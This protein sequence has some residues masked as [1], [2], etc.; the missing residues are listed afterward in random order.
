MVSKIGIS[1][2]ESKMTEVA[3]AVKQETTALSPD[4]ILQIGLSFWASKALL[5]AIGLQV[6]TKLS[7]K[8]M[9]GKDLA[10]LVGIHPRGA[11]DFFDT[12]LSLGMLE[13][14]NGVYE[15]SAQSEH[16]LVKGKG[17]YIGGI[18]E[19]SDSRM[20][21]L[22]AK[23]TEALKTGEPQMG[24]DAEE[25]K[26]FDKVYENPLALE[27]F[28]SAMTGLTMGTAHA[29]AEKF[30]WSK[31]KNFADV[32][33]AQGAV[34]AVLAARHPHLKGIG[35][36]LPQVKPVFEKYIA[37]NG[38]R[39]RVSFQGGDFFND[40]LPNVD[41]II[42]GHILHDWGMEKKRQLIAS[43]YAALPAGGAYIV[44]E[45]MID[46]DRR[47]NTFGLLMSLNMLVHTAG[48]FDYTGADCQ[49]WMKAAGF[50]KTYVEHLAGP[51]YMIVGI[52]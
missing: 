12:L 33:C 24:A 29:I 14:T 37:A 18:L 8:K 20:Y 42:M 26:V 25:A 21:D 39:D 38:Q 27:E 22:W 43:T 7:G 4:N 32:G 23:L 19:Y 28:L 52:K 34:P 35:F 2:G 13:R 47:K 49:G 51:D 10:A 3:T 11:E 31:Y 9:N 5:S 48:G 40:P 17:S 16:F 6:F 44:F 41:V 30:D 1:T 45:S 15:N 36:D 46:D 50:K